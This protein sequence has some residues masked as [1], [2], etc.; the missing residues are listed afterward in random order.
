MNTDYCT[1]TLKSGARQGL[2]CRGKISK[3][4]STGL[5]CHRHLNL[6]IRLIVSGEI[7]KDE[8]NVLKEEKR[9]KD[10]EEKQ[11]KFEEDEKRKKF[12]DEEKKRKEEIK[13]TKEEKKKQKVIK[14]NKIRNT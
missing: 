6:E 9:V 14:T 10:N 11:K 4:S 13:R 7:S 12:E 5:F 1:E 8:L 2:E 3:N